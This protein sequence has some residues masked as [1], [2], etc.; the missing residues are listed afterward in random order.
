MLTKAWASSIP[1][2]TRLDFY[3]KPNSADLVE[4]KNSRQIGLCVISSLELY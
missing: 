3:A 1:H 2:P 4:M